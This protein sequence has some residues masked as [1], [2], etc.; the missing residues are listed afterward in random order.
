[1]LTYG[2]VLVHGDSRLYTAT[3]IRAL[4]GVVR[5]LFLTALISLRAT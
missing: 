3:R 2:V 1:M 5:S 4:L